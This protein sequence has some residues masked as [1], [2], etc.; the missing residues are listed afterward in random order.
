MVFFSPSD[1]IYLPVLFKSGK[2]ISKI[3]SRKALS[4]QLYKLE[5]KPSGTFNTFKSG[6]Y[7]ILR[8]TDGAAITLP[9]VKTDAGRETLTVIATSISEKLAELLNPCLS[10]IELELEG[11]FGQPFQ[12]EKFGTV[13]CVANRES[14]IPLY[15]VLAALK[16]AG[17]HI[18]CLLTGAVSDDQVLENELRNNS[19]DF[20]SSADN[21]LRR[22]SQ[23]LEQ[24]LGSRKYNQVFTIGSVKTIRETCTVCKATSTPVQAMLYLNEQSQIGLHGIFRVSICANTRALCV[25]GHNFNAYYN[26]FEE[27]RK[28]FGNENNEPLRTF[29]L[30]SKISVPV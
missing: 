13:L 30:L 3:V 10:H 26:S 4:E 20:I 11:P 28:R 15:P 17:N 8:T 9:I 2:M 1:S 27:L 7:V 25:D 19:D 5:I 12:I 6:Q 23:L 22:S 29:N 16:A 24:T 14:M 18:T 21:T